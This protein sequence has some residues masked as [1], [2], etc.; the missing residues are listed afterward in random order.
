MRKLGLDYESVKVHNPDVI[1]VNAPGYGVDGPYGTKPAY[2]PSIGA[3]SGIPLANVGSTVEERDDLTMEQVQDGARRLS[4]ASAMANAQADGFAALGVATANPLRV[5]RLAIW[6]Q[7]VRSCSARCSTP[8]VTRCRHRPSRIRELRASRH[9]TPTYAGWVRCTAST[10]RAADTCSS[11]RRRT[12]NGRTLA[13]ALAPYAELV[14]DPRFADA[15]SRRA[16]TS[17]LIAALTEVFA[18]K[19]AVEWE[20]ELLPKGIGCVAVT[21]DAIETIMFDDSFGRASGYVTDVVHPTLDEHPRLAPYI[22][23]SRSRT[24]A[25]PAV[26]NGQ[27]TDEILAEL[28][29]SPDEIADLRER[30]VVG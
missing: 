8:D 25:K 19:S 17:E 28:G 16:H 4:A 29:K 23:F 11:P 3:A 12:S 5:W 30:K 15:A 6:V 1:Y 24:Q 9:P 22:R 7:V 27:Q 20:T 10:T 2:A 26:L 18:G 21:T 14:S 13:G